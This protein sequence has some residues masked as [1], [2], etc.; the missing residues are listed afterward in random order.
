MLREE[1]SGG[2]GIHADA[3]AKLPGN[4]GSHEGGEV[5]DTRFGGGI[6]GH[7][8]QGA[9]GCHAGKVDDGAALLLHH[10]AEEDL[11]GQHGARQVQ[12][13]HPLKLLCLQVEDG[14]RGG[15]GGARHVSAGGV[16]QGVYAAVGG[17]YVAQVLLQACAVG[18][19]G[20]Q[21]EGFAA[22]CLDVCREGVSHFGFAAQDDY[23]GALLCEVQG[24][25]P[26]QY[27]RSAG[28]DHYAVFD[29]E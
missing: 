25:G 14:A 2:D 6:S 15:D 1:E 9:E 27:A 5:R 19:V 23:F 22:G 16:Q 26:S 13:Q 8:R 4:F 18:H 24:D 11:C 12:F 10:R 20:G 21:E 28:D 3:F 17:E 29:V 7:A